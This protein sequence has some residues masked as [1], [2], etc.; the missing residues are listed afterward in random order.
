M[1]SGNAAEDQKRLA[2]SLLLA[3][4]GNDGPREILLRE[5]RGTLLMDRAEGTVK[6]TV[7]PSSGE[8]KEVSLPLD[9]EGLEKRLLEG[10]GDV[11]TPRTF[12]RGAQLEDRFPL[13]EAPHY[14]RLRVLT[15]QLIASDGEFGLWQ[16][17]P[18][19][20]RVLKVSRRDDEMLVLSRP[21]STRSAISFKI[22]EMV[23]FVEAFEAEVKD[24]VKRSPQPLEAWA[25]FLTWELDV[26]VRHTALPTPSSRARRR[27]LTS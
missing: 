4:R 1:H 23:R 6:L 16:Q 25:N 15:E 19:R 14:S 21:G 26:V 8:K 22:S 3:L 11:S 20:G 5:S 27:Q 10:L 13:R 12:G 9:H 17:A 24:L 18:G 7:S 2:D